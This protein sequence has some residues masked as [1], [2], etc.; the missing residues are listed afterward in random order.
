MNIDGSS[1]L[2]AGSKANFLITPVRKYAGS[3]SQE[4]LLKI[5]LNLKDSWHIKLIGD[6]V[7]W[8]NSSLK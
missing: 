5:A 3:I 7:K 6:S 8:N 2:F 1:L 4:A